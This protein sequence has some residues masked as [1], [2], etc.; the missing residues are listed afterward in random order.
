[1][2]QVQAI[3]ESKAHP[4]QAFRTLKGLQR[5]AGRYDQ[6]RFEAACRRA[7]AFGMV[8]LRRIRNI[9]ETQLETAPLPESAPPSQTGQHA[10]VRGSQYYC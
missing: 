4:E 3:F 9:L 6:A 1:M 10:N 8:G 7:N 5:L 2:A